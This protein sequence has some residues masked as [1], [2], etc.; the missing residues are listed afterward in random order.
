ML[1]LL[2][3][4]VRIMLPEPVVEDTCKNK[5]KSVD[6]IKYYLLTSLNCVTEICLNIFAHERKI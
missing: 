4:A 2:E 1:T 3:A 5:F 6:I